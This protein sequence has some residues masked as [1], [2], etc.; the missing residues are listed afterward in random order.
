M[1]A[2][3]QLTELRG[4]SV[5]DLEHRSRD[6]DDQI[7]RLRLRKAM[8]QVEAGH[9]LRPLRRELARIKTLLRVQGVRG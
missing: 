5:T 7:F 6:L 8:G 1:K 2:T 4:M 9:K 3:E